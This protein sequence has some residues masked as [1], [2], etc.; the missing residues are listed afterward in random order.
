MK[1]LM[2]AK[3]FYDSL[4]DEER[5]D[6]HETIAESI[7]FLDEDLQEKI[8]ALLHRVAPELSREIRRINRFTT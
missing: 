1:E 7:F 5:Q 2:Q 3:Q 8:L 4:C 6:L